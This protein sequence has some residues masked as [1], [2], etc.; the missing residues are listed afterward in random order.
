MHCHPQGAGIS[1]CISRASA[2]SCL[3][4]KPSNKMRKMRTA[5]STLSICALTHLKRDELVKS[6]KVGGA[7]VFVSWQIR[8]QRHDDGLCV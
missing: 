5:A 2:S 6:E 8:R 4:S 7:L 3:A 1:P